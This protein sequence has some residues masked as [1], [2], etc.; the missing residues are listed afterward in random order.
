MEKVAAEEKARQGKA[1]PQPKKRIDESASNG[2]SQEDTRRAQEERDAAEAFFVAEWEQSRAHRPQMVVEE[3]VKQAAR[4]QS[5]SKTKADH[6]KETDKKREVAEALL[7]A[8]WEAARLEK[9]AVEEAT[10]AKCALPVDGMDNAAYE[11]HCS[12]F[13]KRVASQRVARGVADGQLDGAL[14]QAWKED[15]P[16]GE[17]TEIPCPEEERARKEAVARCLVC[18]TQVA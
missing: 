9:E 11:A 15:A 8:E 1:G 12:N 5:Q 14:S 6:N 7:Q 10:T 4:V 3:Q 18:M 17:A 16:A 2:L 13:A